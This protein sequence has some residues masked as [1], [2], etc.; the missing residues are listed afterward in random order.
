[1]QNNPLVSVV[2]PVYNASE[3]L[4]EAL[5]SVLDQTYKN[6]EIIVIDDGSTDG[7]EEILKKFDDKRIRY[8]RHEKNQGLIPTLN[9]G[10]ELAQGKYIARMDADDVIHHQKFE[11]QVI[12]LEKNENIGMLGTWMK[13]FG[14]QEGITTYP[15]NF[16]E[17]QWIML[18]RIAFCHASILIRN[19]VLK[20]YG[21]SFDIN[22]LH[23]EDYD[24]GIRFMKVSQITSLAEPLYYYRIHQNSVSN[25]HNV[26]Q[27]HNT[28]R[29]I[30]RSLLWLSVE[31]SLEQ[32]ALFRRFADR[33]FDFTTT[34]LEML[35]PVLRGLL[36]SPSLPDYSRSQIRQRLWH[37]ALNARH[38]TLQQKALF[39]RRFSQARLMP[40][41]AFWLQRLL[42]YH[43]RQKIS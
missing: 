29:I 4:E 38:L 34:E 7:S 39:L 37:L 3:F 10:F 14:M 32:V 16:E 19:S 5:T 2:L 30:Q 28:L 22:F 36:A 20:E 21:L 35:E 25:K 23:A 6:L 13:K 43:L 42:A 27:E 15:T 33:S 40:L 18:Y 31:A 17:I 12:F 8:Y 24:F 11:K 1:M 26:L 9:Q 41:P